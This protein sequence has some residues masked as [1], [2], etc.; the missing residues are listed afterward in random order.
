M[1]VKYDC[2]LNIG[3]YLSLFWCV[4]EKE[5][6]VQGFDEAT[7]RVDCDEKHNIG[8]EQCVIYPKHRTE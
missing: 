3:T 8:L 7:N 5:T 1:I 2:E 4:K 6:N